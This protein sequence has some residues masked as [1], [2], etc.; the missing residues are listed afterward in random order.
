MDDLCEWRDV[1]PVSPA[2]GWIGGKKQLAKRLCALIEATPHR[3]Y[4]EPFVGMGGVF[5]RR[6]QAARAEAINDALKWQVASRAD[7]ER[8]AA[9]PPELLT[10]LERA[11]RFLYLQKLT[12]GGKVRSKSFGMDTHGPARFDLNRLGGV[13]EA[14]HERLGGVTID[15][16]DWREFIA[17]WDRPETLFYVDPPYYG[18]EGYYRAAFPRADHEALAALLRG[19]KGRFVLTMNDSKETRAIYRETG[20]RIERAEL[21]Y[22]AAGGS[23]A[24]RAAEIIVSRL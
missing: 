15:C 18:T 4:A 24:K 17:R 7:F 16:L 14:V 20:G 10:D 5:L 9:Q 13:L 6:R 8:L 2:A 1:A 11:A 21:T 22:T 3:V 19:I 23:G 12:F